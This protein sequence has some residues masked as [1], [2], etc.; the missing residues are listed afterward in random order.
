S[1]CRS[2]ATT[3]SGLCRF[4][5]ICPSSSWPESHTSGR[6]TSLGAD[7]LK[8]DVRSGIGIAIGLVLAIEA[9]TGSSRALHGANPADA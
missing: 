3:S 5:P 1:T 9:G 4:V 7:Q 6:T 8:I 2:L